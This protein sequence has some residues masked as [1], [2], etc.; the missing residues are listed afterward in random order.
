M[1]SI[2]M[3]KTR[4]YNGQSPQIPVPILYLLARLKRGRLNAAV[5]PWCMGADLRLAAMDSD[6]AMHAG[7]PAER[8]RH[9]LVRSACAHDIVL[10]EGKRES[11]RGAGS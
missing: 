11:L 4:D 10:A 8:G 5:L 6:A 3:T 1:D 7:V 2:A 9:V